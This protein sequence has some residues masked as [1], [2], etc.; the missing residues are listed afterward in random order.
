VTRK[1]GL[2][3]VATLPRTER[4]LFFAGEALAK[5]PWIRAPTTTDARDGLGPLYNARSCTACHPNGGRG[6]IPQTATESVLGGGL[7][8]LS[9]PG[10]NRTDGVVPEPRYG[11]QLQTKSVALASLLG[12]EVEREG[13]VKP[14]AKLT[15]TWSEQVFRYADG[16][17]VTLR[18]PEPHLEKLAYGPLS[19]DVMMSLRNAPP[20]YGLGLVEAIPPSAVAVLAD[21]DD[22]DGDGI[23]G[24]INWVWDRSAHRRAPGR[25]GLK[26]NQP[27]LH[28]QVASAFAGDIGITNPVFP[29]QPCT[30][31]Q[32]ECV[33]SPSGVDDDGVELSAELLAL[34]VDFVRNV[35][36]PARTGAEHEDVIAGRRAFYQQGCASCHHASFTTASTQHMQLDG[37]EIWPY[38]DFLL[39]DMGDGL[40][41]GRPDHHASGREWRTAPLWAD[42]RV[43]GTDEPLHLMHDGRARTHEE[44]ILWHGGE[45]A[46]ARDAFAA[47]PAEARADLLRFLESL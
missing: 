2:Q 45:A 22:E 20:L 43:R 3:P 7:L 27:S 17:E 35:G 26:A 34:V 29:D 30:A 33:T 23:S 28:Q 10:A 12:R 8:R 11:A 13:E 1:P 47:A 21:P 46:A 41:D 40:A 4:S 19:D 18:K 44:A 9:V 25:F 37:H 42:S 39:H 6:R 36:V 38:S 32:E 24:R 31:S 14:E 15:L 5:Q 16:G